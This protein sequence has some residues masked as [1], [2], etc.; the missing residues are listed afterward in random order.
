MIRT[1]A[2]EFLCSY[3]SNKG[4]RSYLHGLL[5]RIDKEG[6]ERHRRCVERAL[7]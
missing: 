7:L 3:S 4:D 6:S 5:N 2:I 1:E